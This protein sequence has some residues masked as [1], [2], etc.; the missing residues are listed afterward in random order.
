MSKSVNVNFDRTVSFS[1]YDINLDEL[2]NA[3]LAHASIDDC[4]VCARVNDEENTEL[5]AYLVLCGP[6]SQDTM[7]ECLSAD[8]AD[9]L[10]PVSVPVSSLPITRDGRID[11]QALAELPVMD[12]DL[13]ARWEAELKNAMDSRFA[14]LVRER[15]TEIPPLHLSDL[16]PGWV[17]NSADNDREPAPDP[18]GT[19]VDSGKE[20]PRIPAISEGEE[21]GLSRQ[22]PAILAEVLQRAVNQSP[23]KGVVYIQAD[24]TTV[25]QSYPELLADAERILHGLRKLGLKPGDKIIFQ[26]DL[27]QDFISAFWASVLGGFVVVPVS[28]APG[29]TQENSAVN[30]LKNTWQALGQPLILTGDN[31]LGAVRSVSNLYGLSDFRVETITNLRREKQDQ[32]WHASQPEDLAILLLTSGSTGAPKA[33]MQSNGSL[34]ARSAANAKM[35]G[36]TSQ[37][38]SLNWLP[39]DHVGGL[40]MFH[41]ADV[42]SACQQIQANTSS[43]LKEP[44]V[45]LDWIDSY[46][47]T[48]TWAPNFAFGLVNAQEGAIRERNWDLSSMRFILNGGEA[49]VAKTARKFLQ[50]LAPHGLPATAM[51]PAWGMS[52]TCSGVTFNNGFS[53]D[54]TSD[55]DLFVAVGDPIPGFAMRIVDDQGRVVE[56]GTD[57]HLQVKG[58]SVTTG[59]YQNPELNQEAFTPD[60]WF[61]TGDIGQI[62]DGSLIIT[63]RDKN[64]IIVN[65]VNYHSHEIENVVES[66]DGVEVSYTAAFSARPSGSESDH[67]V[68]A[69]SP[70][71]SDIDNIGELIARIRTEVVRNAGI[72][73]SFLVPVD[74]GRIPKTTIGKIQHSLLRKNFET[75]AFDEILKSVDLASRN[76]NTLPDWFYRRIWQHREAQS[77]KV[78]TTGSVLVFADDSGLGATLCAD[79]GEPEH[80]V[81][82]VDKGARFS[83]QD[84]HRY[85]LD[86]GNVEHYIQLLNALLS[87]D[88]HIDRVLHLWT[89]ELNSDPVGSSEELE[90]LQDLGAYS[91]LCLVQ[92]L[93]RVLDGDHPVKLLVVSSQ[94][95]AVFPEEKVNYTH[96][97][98]HGLVK[99][100]PQEMDWL[101]CTHVD[102]RTSDFNE[103]G[104]QILQ[105]LESLPRDREVAYRNGHRWVSR[106]EKLDMPSIR[107]ES[108]GLKRGGMY[109]LSGGLGGIGLEIAKFLLRELS[110][111]V[112]LVGRSDPGTPE[113]LFRDSAETLQ[114]LARLGGKVRYEVA[115][116]TDMDRM[117]E[118]VQ[119]AQDGWDC[120]LDGVIH[121]AGIF[122]ECL[123][124]DETRQGFYRQLRP[125]I[126][127]A[128]ILHQLVR[129][130]PQ[131][132]FV[133]SSSING[134][135]GGFSVGAYAAAN[136]FL[137]CFSE[138]QRN[139]CSMRSY[140]FA[141]S[142]WDEVGMSRGYAKK[143]LTLSRGYHAI[144]AQQGLN[145]LQVGLCREPGDMF[146]GLDGGKQNIQRFLGCKTVSSP[147]ELAVFSESAGGRSFQ[148]ELRDRVVYDRFGTP[149]TCVF[150]VV[151][152][153]PVISSG[154]VDLEALLNLGKSERSA[155]SPYVAP[156]SGAEQTIGQ[157]WQ[158]TLQIDG[159]GVND[160]FFDLGGDSLL[161]GQISRKLEETFQRKVSMTDVFEYP[162]IKELAAF[163]EGGQQTRDSA[164][165]E[166]SQSR[167]EKRRQR[168]LHRKR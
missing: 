133:S 124:V 76:A 127:G 142:L 47:A 120:K 30:K 51:H 157:I 109:L 83:R 158:D 101:N 135:F 48:V 68:I 45:W 132:V 18:T 84:P 90:Q 130:N 59:Y 8:I 91:L 78:D 43:V 69:F 24:G 73:P 9:E 72:N 131:C 128:W 86:P 137:D 46:R 12:S 168:M 11:E 103:G 97:A 75:G 148:C 71:S 61:I 147:R 82:R 67:L 94:S 143:D 10:L 115:D 52:E 144:S 107:D 20:A 112:L 37:E 118:V 141:W 27:N 57:G 21:L 40:V 92:A 77:G 136:S 15:S 163:L 152:K 106:L 167:G 165:V 166:K 93:A 63:G 110:A 54:E 64:E 139:Q 26:F 161:V 56:E 153:I 119:S 41:L 138:Y 99:T 36:F 108:A 65:G 34:I 149:S 116:V 39:M 113:N 140:S 89:H 160:N 121:L 44:L 7:R 111:R 1:A 33:V 81:I 28:I 17:G 60:G 162:T 6:F 53:L 145:S 95:Q 114:A 125:K 32:E 49:I 23:D 102:L 105:E 146:V 35:N 50:L 74:P 87:D 42:F 100:I 66:V 31:L 98:V 2:E 22:D 88:V 5:V 164:R 96:A 4:H 19:R 58:P 104:R 150:E 155:K 16:I 3:L 129:D 122:R 55:D 117:Q 80:P 13:V 29:Y 14:V 151:E 25:A 70:T 134:F 159:V 38:V 156:Q 126:L 79:L 154:K 62:R 123:L 85:C